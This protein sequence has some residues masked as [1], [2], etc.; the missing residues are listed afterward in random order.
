MKKTATLYALLVSSL[1]FADGQFE[2]NQLCVANGCF[3]GDAPGWPVEITESGSYRLTSNLDVPPD[4]IGIEMTGDSVTLDLG[5]FSVQSDAICSGIPPTCTPSTPGFGVGILAN[6][7]ETFIQNGTVRGFNQDCIQGFPDAARL[8]NLIVSS[9]V[10][11]GIRLINFG[12]LDS[13]SVRFVGN[14]GAALSSLY[15]VIDSSFIGAGGFGVSS[16][17]CRGN[18]FSNNAGSLSVTQENCSI[19]DGS[20]YCNGAPCP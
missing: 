14:R 3:E 9:C 8:E 4:L 15:W 6:S 5:G 12:T 1:A 2:I 19:T 7:E 13:V 10:G 17:I 20:N 11:D 16:G 18:I